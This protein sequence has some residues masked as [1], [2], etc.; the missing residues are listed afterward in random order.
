MQHIE[1]DPPSSIG[2]WLKLGI[3]TPRN[4]PSQS[5]FNPGSVSENFRDLYALRRRKGFHGCATVVMAPHRP[6][7]RLNDGPTM[8]IREGESE[9]EALLRILQAP[10]PN[11]HADRPAETPIQRRSRYLQDARSTVVGLLARCDS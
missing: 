5:R 10:L 4:S 8:S 9:R 2:R 11:L 6:A 7:N 1:C 3:D